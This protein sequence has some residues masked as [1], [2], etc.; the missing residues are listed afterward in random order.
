M[1]NQPTQWDNGFFE[2]LLNH[3]WQLTKS[4]GCMA[5]GTGVY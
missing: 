3:D 1:D 2:M 4:S 5:V